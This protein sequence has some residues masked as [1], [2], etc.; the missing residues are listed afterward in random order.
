MISPVNY[1][2]SGSDTSSCRFNF[3]L[4][5]SANSHSIAQALFQP[6][7]RK[8]L[9]VCP[10][11]NSAECRRSRRRTLLDYFARVVG[12][13]P[14]RCSRCSRRLRSRTTPLAHSLVAHCAICGNI[15]V[16]RVASDLADGFAAPL[17]RT[18]GVPAFRCIPCRHKFFSVLPLSKEVQDSDY[19]IDKIAS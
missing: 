15:E 7:W 3:A 1:L 10:V 5:T 17:W 6:R 2:S 16:K 19:K 4:L 13:V 9:M 14:W 11:C 8:T 12:S 18:L